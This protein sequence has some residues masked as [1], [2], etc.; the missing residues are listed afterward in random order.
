M[1]YIGIDPGLDGAVAAI[2]GCD[3]TVQFFDTPTLEVTG[4]KKTRR[5]YDVGAM[6]GC[7]RKFGDED[8]VHRHCV[9][10]VESVHSM[11]DQGTASSFTFGMG[12]GMWQG[13]LSALKMPYTL[14]PPQRWKKAMMDGMGKEKDASRVVAMRLFPNADLHLKKHHGRADALLLAEYIRRNEE[15]GRNS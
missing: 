12:F 2:D 14:V 11:P 13:I 9:C 7:L 4:G 15:G 6:A 1:F 10:A 5:V 3:G 8:F